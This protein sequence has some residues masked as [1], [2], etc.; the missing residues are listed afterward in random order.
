MALLPILMTAS[1]ST[2]GMQG[3]CFSDQER[4]QMYIN[5]LL[6]Y[7]K[8]ILTDKRQRIVFAENSGWDIKNIQNQLPEDILQQIE[9]L[10]IDPS[11]FDI[12]KGKGFNE[13]LLIRHS[14]NQSKFIQNAKAFF[15]VTGRY[16]IYNLKKFVKQASRAIYFDGVELFGDMK[17]HNLYDWLGLGWNGHSFE[18]RLFGCTNNYYI[19]EIAPNYVNCNDY[20]GNLMEDEL[21]KIMK[22][23]NRKVHLRFRQEPHLGG[24]EGSTSQAVSFSKNQDSFKGKIK[25]FIGNTVRVVLP[26]F[27]F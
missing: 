11:E 15:K 21:F 16:P 13:M 14:I 2:R 23:T 1:V 12:S 7:V 27:W 24:L 6:Y 19:N 18:C 22:K 25:R 5:T 8:N 20:N 4:E 17:D 9:F 3:A 26:W 10:S